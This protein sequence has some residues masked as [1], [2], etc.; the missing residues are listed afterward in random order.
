MNVIARQRAA[1]DNGPFIRSLEVIEPTPLPPTAS[2]LRQLCAPFAK[3]LARRAWWQLVNTLIPFLAIWATMA[4]SVV[5]DWGYGYRCDKRTILKCKK[6]NNSEEAGRDKIPA[7]CHFYIPKRDF[8]VINI[9]NVHFE[10]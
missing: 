5:S 4:W 9:G 8:Y 7:S 10:L 6:F 1:V 3:P 2:Q